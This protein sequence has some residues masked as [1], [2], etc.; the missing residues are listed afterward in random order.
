MQGTLQSPST[1]VSTYTNDHNL[2]ETAH[3]SVFGS[4]THL[5]PPAQF[6]TSPSNDILDVSVLLNSHNALTLTCLPSVHKSLI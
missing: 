6:L 5:D 1:I 3:L 4:P 2:K